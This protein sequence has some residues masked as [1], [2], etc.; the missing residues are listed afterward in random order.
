MI[1][2]LDVDEEFTWINNSY[3]GILCTGIMSKESNANLPLCSRAIVWKWK[4]KS[5]IGR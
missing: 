5:R 2:D 4:N 1:M 3:R